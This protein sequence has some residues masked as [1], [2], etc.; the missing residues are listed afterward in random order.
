MIG[1]GMPNAAL[2]FPQQSLSVPVFSISDLKPLK[3]P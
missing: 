3:V 1:M 2:V